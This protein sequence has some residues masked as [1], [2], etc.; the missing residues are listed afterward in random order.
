MSSASA[1]MQHRVYTAVKKY[2]DGIDKRVDAAILLQR[3]IEL[4]NGI[5]DIANGH[6]GFGILTRD[7][8]QAIAKQLLVRS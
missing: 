4:E 3:V 1:E 6:D 2:D 5:L 8:M 7:G